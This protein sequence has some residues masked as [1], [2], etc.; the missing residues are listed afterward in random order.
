MAEGQKTYPRFNISQRAQHWVMTISFTVLAITGLP[1]RYALA[2]WAEWMIEA[3]G[4]IE[5]V[6]II[7]RV[8][9]V[10]L[11]LVTAYHFVSLAY[12]V[13]VKRSRMTLLPGLKD[14][15]DLLDSVRY[16]LGLAQRH[17]RYP[18]FSVAEKIEYWAL[19]WGTVVMIITGFMLW[20]PIATTRFL[21]GEFVPA[22]K[23]AHSAEALLA[24]LAVL[25]W[26]FYAVHVKTVN[27]S[28]FSGKLT[29]EE[30]EVEHAAEL[31]ELDAGLRRMPVPREVKRRR[32]RVFV[33]IATVILLVMVVAL[34]AFLTFEET[35]IATVPPAETV[36]AFIPATPTPTATPT[37]TPTPTQTPVATA[38]PEVGAPAQPPDEQT[39][40]SL[41]VIPHPLEG[42]E[43]C[44]MCH[45]EAGAVPYPPDHVGRPSATCLVCHAMTQDE[46]TLP[47]SVKHDLE[48]RENC[49]MCHAV[50]LLP[51]SHKTGAFS[52]SDCLLCHTPGGAEPTAGAAE[53]PAAEAGAG[54]DVS[55]AG[56]V[57]P[58]L[59]ANCASCH[60]E[61]AMGGLQ[62]TD[63]ETLMAGGQ[64]GPVVLPGSPEES[65]V[66]AQMGEEHPAVLTGDNLQTLVD[67]IAAG[68]EDN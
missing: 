19:I 7:H 27:R 54:G 35:A 38:T 5:T 9:A 53:Q 20:N 2:G 52:N 66:V 14:V 55:F 12:T 3:M 49:L 64:N 26:H 50:D 8:S 47:V 22:A 42:R 10:V 1:Q 67:W 11:I 44:L 68:A 65:P 16:S 18:H 13:F 24:V 56:D 33:P 63:Y 4:G 31:D 28:M 23:A 45:S 15:T 37:I 48:G 36:Q 59:E 51:E 43:D 25:I 29:R 32:E 61:M 17:P 62:T 40:L 46:S 39:L 57:L 21:P 6:R 41:M 58:L 30:M 60:G 34:Y